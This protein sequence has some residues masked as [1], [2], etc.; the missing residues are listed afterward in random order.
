LCTANDQVVRIVTNKV[1]NACYAD[2]NLDPTLYEHLGNDDEEQQWAN[3]RLNET[4][5]KGVMM[6]GILT[7][8]YNNLTR[9]TV[10]IFQEWLHLV[11]VLLHTA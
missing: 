8:D 10:V 6:W 5:S 2:W 4:P 11:E 9:A 3:Y 7:N 1:D